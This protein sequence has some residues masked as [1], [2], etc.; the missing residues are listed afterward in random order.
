MSLFETNFITTLKFL[1]P[2]EQSIL[3]YPLPYKK[4][5]HF[6]Y[7][8]LHFFQINNF[9]FNVVI[10]LI[11]LSIMSLFI[12]SIIIMPLFIC[13]VVSRHFLYQFNYRN[14]CWS[15]I[16]FT[17]LVIFV[18]TFRYRVVHNGIN[19]FPFVKFFVIIIRLLDINHSGNS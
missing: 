19:V 1:S 18:F 14:I 7:Q 5:V 12:S 8:L 6:L 13:C 4:R 16:Y 15:G 10:L 9:H 11:P 2:N 3:R 17:T